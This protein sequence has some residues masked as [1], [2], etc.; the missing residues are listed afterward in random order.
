ML[1]SYDVL[2][3]VHLY[4]IVLIF[5]NLRFAMLVLELGAKKTLEWLE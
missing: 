1:V 4:D 3:I 2:P 5:V